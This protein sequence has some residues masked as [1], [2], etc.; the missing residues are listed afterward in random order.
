[1]QR[2]KPNTD[3]HRSAPNLTSVPFHSFTDVRQAEAFKVLRVCYAGLYKAIFST[4]SSLLMLSE[5]W[6]ASPSRRS[7]SP[8][9][10]CAS[11][12]TPLTAE[13]FLCKKTYHM[14]HMLQHMNI[15]VSYACLTTFL[16]GCGKLLISHWTFV[17]KAAFPLFGNWNL[18]TVWGNLKLCNSIVIIILECQ[19]YTIASECVEVAV[20][21]LSWLK[22]NLNWNTG[23]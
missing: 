8:R 10:S 7:P 5:S 6:F 22:S 16:G 11:C 13:R 17:S 2:P 20:F 9:T 21:L 4:S 12:F 1:M 18:L 3:R 14:S 15:H 23:S 19:R